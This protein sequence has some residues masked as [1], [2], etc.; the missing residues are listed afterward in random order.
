MAR[1]IVSACL[2]VGV[3]VLMADPVDLARMPGWDIVIEADNGS[4]AL[5]YAAEELRDHLALA[6]SV[7]LPI[8]SE[9]TESHRHIF[10][11]PSAAMLASN[12]GFDTEQF[13]PEQLRIVIGDGNIAIAGGHPRGTLYGVYTFLEKYLGVRFLTRGHTFVPPVRDALVLAPGSYDFEPH[14]NF[15][16]SFYGEVN[17][18]AAF[19]ARMRC[20]TVPKEEKYGGRTGRILISHSFGRQIPSKIYG[21]AHP[22]YYCQIDGK[23]RA[24]VNSD[25]YDNEPCLANPDVLKIVTEAVLAEIEEHPDRSNVEVSQNDNDK[26]CRCDDCAKIDAR[27]GTPM[28]SLLTFVNA[29]ADKVAVRHPHV[30]VGTLA[31]WY[32]RQAPATL[33]PRS[34]VQIQLCSI[35]CSMLQPLSDPGCEMNLAFCRDFQD[36]S[37]RCNDIAIWN[38]N[39]NFRNYLLPCPN[40]RV[41]E[42]NIRFFR[43]R[44]VKAVFMQAA[45][46]AV[47]AEMSELRNYM[48]ANLLWNPDRN[49]RVLM[50]EF[51]DLHYRSAAPPIR[52]YLDL[53]HDNADRRG[54]VKNC[55]GKASDYGIDAEI[56]EAGLAAFDEA[57]RL[58]DDEVVRLRV[59]KASI[60]VHRAAIEEAWLWSEQQKE[61]AESR[62]MPNDISRRTRRHARTLFALCALHGVDRW[63]EGMKIEDAATQLRRAYGLTPGERF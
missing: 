22:E 23:R 18:D 50:D 2:L 35:E 10:V 11:G 58:A 57:I 19:A 51:L 32:S 21:E 25:W 26:Y 27:E 24:Q 40:L 44:G 54:L 16:W 61:D 28:G 13:G 7:R 30:K 63:G 8:A 56:V 9:V 17:R 48:I 3:R 46:N 5:E 41:I 47:G 42:P 1:W 34:N 37:R 55:F 31:Y 53:L 20:N 6:L 38:Y 12:V 49:G 4:R 60:C 52:R 43:D 15:R 29:V 33:K 45:G 59:E 14:F 36:W 39:T 62:V